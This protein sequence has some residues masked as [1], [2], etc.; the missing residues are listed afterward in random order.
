M[1]MT[2]STYCFDEICEKYE[3]LKEFDMKRAN[4]SMTQEDTRS[5]EMVTGAMAGNLQQSVSNLQ[6]L[7]DLS[8]WSPETF[9]AEAFLTTAVPLFNNMLRTI[10]DPTSFANNR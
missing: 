2:D 4:N 3:K 10:V 7:R 9:H 1:I 5:E 6:L 8:S